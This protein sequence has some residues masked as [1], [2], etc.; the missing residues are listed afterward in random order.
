ML[1]EISLSLHQRT[2]DGEST[3]FGRWVHLLIVVMLEITGEL[4]II[5]LTRIYC[6]SKDNGIN[7]IHILDIRTGAQ[8]NIKTK[9]SSIFVMDGLDC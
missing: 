2:T 3:V 1:M 6:C 5:L 4:F 7:V 8:S 9:Y